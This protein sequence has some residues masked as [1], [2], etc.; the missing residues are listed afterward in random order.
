MVGRCYI[1]KCML[2][3]DKL[4]DRVHVEHVSAMYKSVGVPE[5]KLADIAFQSRFS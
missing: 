3:W 5:I 4:R 2:K 1:S